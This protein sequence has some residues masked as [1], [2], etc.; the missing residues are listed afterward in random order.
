MEIYFHDP[1]Y[2]RLEVD[3][4]YLHGFPAAV[5]TLY[6]MRLQLLRA[7]RNEGDLTA[8]RCLRFSPLETRSSREYSVHLNSRYG[9]IVE[10]RT[11]SGRSVLWVVEVR[12]SQP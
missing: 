6:R 9:L 10:L 2:D 7:A 12:I 4:A 1:S 11:Q 5:V 3:A 8:M